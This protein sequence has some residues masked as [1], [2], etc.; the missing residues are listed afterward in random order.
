[1]YLPYSI[2]DGWQQIRKDFAYWRAAG[3]GTETADPSS[4]RGGV[5][6]DPP[7]R[8]KVTPP[9]TGG[10]RHP[11]GDAAPPVARFGLLKSWGGLSQPQWLHEQQENP[12]LLRG[13]V[14]QE[15]PQAR[16]SGRPGRVVPELWVQR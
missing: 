11:H 7:L 5:E 9:G 8:E 15:E 6:A 4:E 2:V 10:W 12:R 13:R 3:K 1:G 16:S 14:R